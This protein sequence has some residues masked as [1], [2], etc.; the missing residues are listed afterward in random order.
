MDLNVFLEWNSK[1]WRQNIL[2]SLEYSYNCLTASMDTV[3]TFDAI[4]LHVNIFWLHWLNRRCWIFIGI[5]V[6]VCRER[7]K[8]VETTF[9]SRYFLWI[10]EWSE[11]SSEYLKKIYREFVRNEALNFYGVN[12]EIVSELEVSW[13]DKRSFKVSYKI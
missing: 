4:I 12:D 7:A 5:V 9:S 2:P 13:A 10:V 3:Q 6:K 1:F 11:S 8:R